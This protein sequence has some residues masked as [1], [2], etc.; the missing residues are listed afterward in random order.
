M[1][2][3]GDALLLFN[4]STLLGAAKSNLVARLLHVCHLNKILV[5]HGGKNGGFIDDGRKIRAAKHG[6]ASRHALQVHIGSH[7]HFLGVHRKNLSTAL[8]I[9]KLHGHGA[10]KAAWSCQR[11][12]KHVR[13]IGGGNHNHL[14]ISVKAVH[15]HQNRVQ[16]LLAFIMSA[17]CEATTT[18][19]ANGVHFVQENNAR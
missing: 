19:A 1:I 16:C 5:K 8:H 13:A 9:W 18:A 17:S 7:L 15:F 6:R 3:R 4:A 10:I 11:R 14:I 12:I 2:R